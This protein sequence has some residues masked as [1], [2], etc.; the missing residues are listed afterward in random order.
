MD[1]INAAA[2]K[3]SMAPQDLQGAST[4]DEWASG[5][6][7]N[8]AP[9]TCKGCVSEGL[10]DIAASCFCRECAIELCDPCWDKIHRFGITKTHGRVVIEV[11][12]VPCEGLDEE[13]CIYDHGVELYC[14]DCDQLLCK[15]CWKML[16]SK[17]T[18]KNHG[19]MLVVETERLRQ[20]A[21]TVD[22]G[23]K[24]KGFNHFAIFDASKAAA[25][26]LRVGNQNKDAV[27]SRKR[28]GGLA[29]Y[30][31][32]TGSNG[33]NGGP[34]SQR[35]AK[36]MTNSSSKLA[37]EVT[38]I[39]GSEG[40]LER[41][42]EQSSLTW[43]VETIRLYAQDRHA[44]RQL[45][46][47]YKRALSSTSAGKNGTSLDKVENPEA[48]LGL[49]VKA[50]KNVVYADHRRAIDRLQTSLEKDVQLVGAFEVS[51]C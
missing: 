17:G 15:A 43:D 12:T 5:S 22:G 18:R 20:Q 8:T 46:F 35:F 25:W 27:G 31:F 49:A 33:D 45:L 2:E 24:K 21:S 40:P 50:N 13:G 29:A 23:E 1:A 51:C 30:G 6:N 28:K 34:I 42:S 47:G 26:V 32:T 10:A 38:L 48:A 16:H 39:V 3:S 7:L 37:G 36:V 14:C 11:P 41:D 19:R 44:N 4:E 9:K